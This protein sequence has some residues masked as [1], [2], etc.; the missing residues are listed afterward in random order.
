[1]FI[2]SLSIL[3]GHNEA[4]L[5]PSLFQTEQVQFH[6]SLLDTILQLGPHEVKAD[7]DSHPP[8]PAGQPSSDATQDNIG[9]SGCKYTLLV[10]VRFFINQ[11]IWVLLSTATPLKELFSQFVYILYASFE[12]INLNNK[13]HSF[14]N[15][16]SEIKYNSEFS[17]DYKQMK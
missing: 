12:L 1:M 16:L 5:Q 4:S 9:S 13:S 8:A 6:Q 15:H 2:T 3:E 11:G 7:R 17:K 14:W 10:Y